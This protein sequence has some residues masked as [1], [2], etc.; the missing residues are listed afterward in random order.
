M[1][2]KSIMLVG[3][4][5][6][7]KS[8][9]L[10]R[11]W[12]ALQQGDGPV[13]ASSVPG[14]IG[15]VENVYGHLLKGQFAARTEPGDTSYN[16]EFAVKVSIKG[17]VETPITEILVPDVHGE[18]WDSA[19]RNYELPTEWM[20]RLKESSSAILFLRAN[21]DLNCSPL[22]WVSTRALLRIAPNTTNDEREKLPTQVALVE[23]LRLLEYG[24]K[25][26]ESGKIR[27]VALIITAWDALHSE[28]S[29]L[30]PLNF[31]KTEYPLLYGKLMND[32]NLE[33]RLYGVSIVG[34]D[35]EVDEEFKNNFLENDI[36]EAGYVVFDDTNGKTKKAHLTEPIA[37]L[38]GGDE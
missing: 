21:S 28:T 4:P 32:L 18:L 19:V 10:G 14:E 33:V 7:G 11:L 37:W 1:N 26:E 15:Y 5:D 38:I 24:L 30:G 23:L 13:V 31:I 36:D 3:L 25:V 34:G 29:K 27:K 12:G 20:A 16:K 9:Y 17:E 22:D 6:S 2:G 8:N 35:L